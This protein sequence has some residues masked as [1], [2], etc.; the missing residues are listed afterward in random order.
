M[1]NR[2]SQY[3]DLCPLSGEVIEV[4]E[5]LEAAP[6]TINNDPYGDGWICRIARHKGFVWIA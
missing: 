1:S 5:D 6:E 4:N 2:S 3:L